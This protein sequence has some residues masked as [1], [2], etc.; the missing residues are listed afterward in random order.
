MFWIYLMLAL[1][2]LCLISVAMCKYADEIEMMVNEMC[3]W[4]NQ[5]K[6]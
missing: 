5:K 1:D 4:L 6:T 3:E 2:A